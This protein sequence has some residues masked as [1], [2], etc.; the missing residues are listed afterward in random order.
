M[1]KQVRD[2]M[3]RHPWFYRALR[4]VWVPP[5]RIYQH[6]YFDD[7][8]D[9]EI[10]PGVSIKLECHGEFVENELFWRGFAGSWESKSLKLWT[11]L[12]KSADYIVDIGANT[13]V[14]ALIAK[15]LNPAAQVMA[16]EPSKRVLT[17]LHRNIALNNLAI[18]TVERAASD[19]SGEATFFDFPTDHQYTASLERGLNGS[20]LGQVKVQTMDEILAIHGF[21]RLDLAKIDVEL[22]EPAVLRGMRQTLETW[23][24]TLLIEVLNDDVEE[25]IRDAIDGLGYQMISVECDDTD[26]TG[27]GRNMLI[28]QPRVLELLSLAPTH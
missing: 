14:Y 9:V 25:G 26:P 20:P 2:A 17:K 18:T 8:I 6:L 11:E 5:H 27:D 15:A 1:L 10:E 23:R 19:K 3:R 13:G 22:H 24:P 28:C 7:I 4:F 16:L 12:A 21:D